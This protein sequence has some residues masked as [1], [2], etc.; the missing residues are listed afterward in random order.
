MPGNT[1]TALG[2]AHGWRCHYCGRPLVPADR[3]P[4]FCVPSS[5]GYVAPDGSSFAHRDHKT[6]RVHGGSDHLDNLVLSCADC[7][8]RKGTLPYDTFVRLRAIA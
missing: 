6:P 3:I 5:G 7:N 8:I 2:N 4:E 1:V